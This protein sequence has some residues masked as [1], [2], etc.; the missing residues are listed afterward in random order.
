[1]QIALR[2]PDPEL[3]VALAT[4]TPKLVDH[5]PTSTTPD[6]EFS[7]A[8]VDEYLVPIS[9]L[10]Q[11]EEYLS[12]VAVTHDTVFLIDELRRESGKAFTP[13][14][15]KVVGRCFLTLLSLGADPDYP[16]PELAPSS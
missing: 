7:Y 16:D 3:D 1:M 10:R 14:E 5:F 15:S 6:G 4:F 9:F 12:D 2:N 13:E 11:A 8:L